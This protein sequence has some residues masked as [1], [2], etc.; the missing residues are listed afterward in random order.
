[1]HGPT[2]WVMGEIG[3]DQQV[4]SHE[5]QWIKGPRPALM[6]EKIKE[7]K[8]ERMALEGENH[9]TENDEEIIQRAIDM[10]DTTVKA[11][12][13]LADLSD[14]HKNDGNAD[15]NDGR[16]DR[17]L[18][19]GLYRPFKKR[20]SA[21]EAKKTGTATRDLNLEWKA[22]KETAD[23]KNKTGKEPFGESQNQNQMQK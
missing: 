17:P 15:E 6:S 9:Y 4:T 21:A 2:E 10:H 20:R 13:I 18:D 14:Q 19:R 22:R 7:V 23:E 12:E 11:V 3:C 8:N 16:G 5:N 1:M